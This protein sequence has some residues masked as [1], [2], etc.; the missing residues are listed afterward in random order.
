MTP[1]ALVST[2]ASVNELM[3]FEINVTFERFIT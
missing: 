3:P 1:A 2:F